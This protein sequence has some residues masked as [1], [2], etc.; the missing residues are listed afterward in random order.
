MADNPFASIEI[1]S[2][3]NVVKGQ[4]GVWLLHQI[5]I[6]TTANDSR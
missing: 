4:I 5:R 6:K 2:H 1:D 3:K